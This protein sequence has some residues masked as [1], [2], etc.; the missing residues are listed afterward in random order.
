[1]IEESRGKIPIEI[2]NAPPIANQVGEIIKAKILQGVFKPGER[3][4]EVDIS[5]SLKISRSPVREAFQRL[6]Q[7]GLITLI[8]RKG[9]FI[10]MPN[11]KHIENLFEVREVLEPLTVALAAKR[12]TASQINQIEEL[13][14][15]TERT[16]E[17]NMYRQYPWDLDYHKKLASCSNNKILE[18]M[19]YQI[20]IGLQLARS[21]SSA[22]YGRAKEALDEHRVIFEAVKQ[23]DAKLA[24]RAMAVHIAK[25]KK[26]IYKIIER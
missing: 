12:A 8:P 19:V 22:E 18:D 13:F 9:A 7:E 14:R 16:I 1:L 2:E 20:N 3:L 23:K 17:Q 26:N 15:S 24:K 25:A 6:S 11:T 21:R 10:S 4:N 5:K